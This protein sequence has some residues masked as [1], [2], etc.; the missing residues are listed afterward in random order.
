MH[1]YASVRYPADESACSTSNKT[2]GGGPFQGV[3]VGEFVKCKQPHT[4]TTFDGQ[5]L[6]NIHNRIVT[7]ELVYT[8]IEVV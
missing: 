8:S 1:V 3:G 5:S 7:S 4:H 2:Q 6:V